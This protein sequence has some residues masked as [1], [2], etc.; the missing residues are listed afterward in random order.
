MLLPGF[1]NMCPTQCW[2][3]F[4]FFLCNLFACY[5]VLF[6]CF[7]LASLVWFHCCF[8]DS[9][10][11]RSVPGCKWWLKLWVSCSWEYP[12]DLT[13]CVASGDALQLTGVGVPPCG[14]GITMA[15][16]H[17]HVVGAPPWL[18]GVGE[19]GT[20]TKHL[21]LRL[22]KGRWHDDC[23]HVLFVILVS[24]FIDC[25]HLSLMPNLSPVPVWESDWQK[26]YLFATPGS[27]QLILVFLSFPLSSTSFTPFS[28]LSCDGI[29][30]CSL[31]LLGVA[32]DLT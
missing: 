31:L 13:F 3:S 23:T 32:L 26:L 15:Q 20:V 24:V 25:V 9:N 16:G 5:L 27:L 4:L 21:H 22:D 11:P 7:L 2:R 19:W 17:Y 29:V 30:A 10:M 8:P 28:T 1:L 18:T 12:L 6:D 14:R